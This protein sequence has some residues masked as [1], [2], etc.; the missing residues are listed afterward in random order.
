ML[1]TDLAHTLVGSG[2]LYLWDKEEL[3]VTCE[4][5]SAN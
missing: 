4:K 1:G 3:D 2:E 5:I